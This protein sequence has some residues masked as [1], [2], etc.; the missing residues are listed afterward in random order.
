MKSILLQLIF[1]I[2]FLTAMVVW[3][4]DLLN[5]NDVVGLIAPLI[6]TIGILGIWKPWLTLRKK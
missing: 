2:C 3:M 1:L 4:W 5:R 6:V